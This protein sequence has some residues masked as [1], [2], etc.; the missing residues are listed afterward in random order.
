MLAATPATD[1]G[2]SIAAGSPRAYSLQVL[3]AATGQCNAAATVIARIAIIANLSATLLMEG[4]NQELL[5][6][7]PIASISQECSPVFRKVLS[8]QIK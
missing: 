2:N 8:T 3:S 7:V 5:G 4:L 1:G 6:I